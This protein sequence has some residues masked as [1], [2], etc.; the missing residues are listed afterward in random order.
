MIAGPD[1]THDPALRSWVATANADDADFPLQNLPFGIF[2]RRDSRESYRVGVAIGDQILDLA[3]CAR[4]GL[5]D[6]VP[7]SLGRLMGD[8]S[9]NRLMA[10]G[11]EAARSLR[12]A[13]VAVLQ[14]GNV[15][16]QRRAESI[17]V[18]IADAELTRPVVVGDYSDFYASVHH[19]TNVG[20]MFRPDNPLLPNYKYVPIGYHGRASS[21]VVSGTSVQRPK[22]QTRDDA[23]APP[24][25]GP[26]KRLDY[27]LEVGMY[28]GAG[29]ALGAPIPIGEAD[30]HLWGISL[31]NDWSARDLQTWEYQP[32]GPFLAKSF[33]TS[34]GPWVVTM[35]A[36]APFRT[37]PTARAP[38][39]PEP[40]PYLSDDADRARGAI[41]L[42]L[43]VLLSSEQ[44][45]REGKPAFRVSRSR[46]VDMY[47]TF[48]QMLAHHSSNG[49]N[50]QPGDLL[51]S[52][53]VSNAEKESRGCLL[54]LT[55][56]GQEPLTL[57]SGEQRTFLADGDEVIMRGVAERSGAR[58]IALGECR[59][60]VMPAA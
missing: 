34:V 41:D 11:R 25:F 60:R 10:E 55:W 47:W 13:I 26:S 28:V 43:E 23:N 37:A 49:C 1:E 5:L 54:E 59:G 31:V 18:E 46:F 4:A 22:G 12:R 30:A 50:M 17:T 58:R 32:L 48:G 51:A 8:D 33:A 38:G 9:L 20:S 56:R 14:L 39:D 36:L 29:N 42:T 27:E 35:D 45:R 53:T 6:G 19:A 3:A 52:G 21:L 16:A 44:M 40:L 24:V 7:A 57:P 2:R 15:N